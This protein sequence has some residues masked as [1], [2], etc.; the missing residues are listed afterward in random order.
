MRTHACI[1]IYICIYRVNPSPNP[2]PRQQ[3]ISE[4][5]AKKGGKAP[6]APQY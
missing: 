4:R 2:N 3:A 6:A 1:C 5:R